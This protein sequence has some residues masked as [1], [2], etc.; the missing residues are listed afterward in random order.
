MDFDGTVDGEAKE[1]VTVPVRQDDDGSS[2]DYGEVEVD[3][4]GAGGGSGQQPQAL[5]VVTTVKTEAG[6][7][8]KEKTLLTY[9]RRSSSSAPSTAAT[10][11]PPLVTPKLEEN[12]RPVRANRG[13]KRRYPGDESDDTE[14]T[15]KPARVR[16]MTEVFA[17]S[18]KYS[19]Q[20]GKEVGQR[21]PRRMRP[22]KRGRPSRA[23]GGRKGLSGMNSSENSDQPRQGN[24]YVCKHEGCDKVF[25]EP[26]GL[27]RH[28]RVHGDRPYVCHYEGCN[29]RFLERSKLKRHYLIHTG[30]KS[31]VC[32][33]EGCGKAFSLDFNLRSHMKTHTGEYHECPHEGCEKKYC[34]NYKLRAHMCK[35]HNMVDGDVLMDA[36]KDLTPEMKAAKKQEKLQMLLTRRERLDDWREGRK[37]RIQELEVELERETKEL[38]KIERAMKKLEREKDLLE[39]DDESEL[40][41]SDDSIEP[42]IEQASC[43]DREVL[44]FAQKLP[45]ADHGARLVQADPRMIQHSSEMVALR[46]S[47]LLPPESSIT[48][49][50]IKKADAIAS[51]ASTW[52]NHA[53]QSQGQN[54][55][56]DGAAVWS[57]SSSSS[58]KMILLQQSEL[59]VT[60]LFAF[61]EQPCLVD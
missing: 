34:Q 15:R 54:Q 53:L 13:I 50:K 25:S 20:N 56:G 43:E 44:V 46:P 41:S 58:H 9:R 27:Y 12:T 32:L 38:G 21:V 35:D 49:E 10:T 57:S 23:N 17:E 29:R 5:E 59:P 30:E 28:A 2:G 11:P 61:Q 19:S 33:H 40:S 22:K 18:A 55:S 37:K 6:V 3:G 1:V 7:D 39:V 8:T 60:H 48:E 42:D 45:T 47:G 31:F 24:L 14:S 4:G 16:S 51:S 36:L 26:G 52:Q